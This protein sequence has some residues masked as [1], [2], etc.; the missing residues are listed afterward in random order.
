MCA[1]WSVA[2]GLWYIRYKGKYA[3]DLLIDISYFFLFFVM[4]VSI[5]T[6]QSQVVIPFVSESYASSA[7]PPEEALP[8][9][10]LKSFPYAV[11]SLL[12]YDVMDRICAA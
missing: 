6:L 4:C 3:G 5:Y 8:L 9:C 2:L 7:D 12:I 1:S 11:R 10:T